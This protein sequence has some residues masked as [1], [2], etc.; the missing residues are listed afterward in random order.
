MAREG[1][2]ICPLVRISGTEADI[3]E[4]E[5]TTGH[6]GNAAEAG[7]YYSGLGVSAVLAKHASCFGPAESEHRG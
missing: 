7:M 4:E 6:S 3:G 1:W 2:A 5:T